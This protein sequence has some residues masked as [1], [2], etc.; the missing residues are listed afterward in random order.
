VCAWPDD[1]TDQLVPM[2]YFEHPLLAQMML[3]LDRILAQPEMYSRVYAESFAVVMLSEIM[4]S[5]AVGLSR[6]AGRSSQVK[7]GL[8]TWRC[9]AVC[10]YI[11]DRLAE[12]ISLGELAAIAQLSQY[13]FCRAF[14]QALGEPPHRYQMCRRIERAKALLAEPSLSVSDVAA[15]VGY[16]SASQFSALFGR[17]T[18]LSP[19]AYRRKMDL[20]PRPDDL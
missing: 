16:N 4:R 13:H 17:M 14:K 2:L 1:G 15:T 8:A 6:G 7:G 3:H 5:Q 9:R 11:E 10:E 12:D 18:G 20:M 19:R